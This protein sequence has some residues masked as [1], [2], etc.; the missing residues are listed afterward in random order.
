[1]AA[2]PAGIA[3]APNGD[4]VITGYFNSGDP[5]KSDLNG[6]TILRLSPAGKPLSHIHLGNVNLGYNFPASGIGVD[7][8]ED[9]IIAY[10]TAPHVDRYSSSGQL[11]AAWGAPK[12]VITR[13]GFP[14]PAF[15]TLDAVGHVYMADTLGDVVREFGSNGTLLHVWGAAGSY[16]GQF[17]H[18]GGI[19]V[20]PNGTIYVSD[21]ENHRIQRLLR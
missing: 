17:H 6:S 7:A 18:P 15:I 14:S 4:V 11:L 13:Y 2:P 9:V 12:P 5:K 16:P 20:A 3:V 10:G 21:T 8:H 1:M 19:A